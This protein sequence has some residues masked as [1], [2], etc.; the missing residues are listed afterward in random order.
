MASSDSEKN[1][2]NAKILQTNVFYK[3]LGI[4]ARVALKLYDPALHN[5]QFLH[6][7]IEFTHLMLEMLEEYSKGKILMIRDKKKKRKVKKVK[8]PR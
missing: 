2:K 1:V 5:A 6:D 3:D 4:I 8:A 7:A